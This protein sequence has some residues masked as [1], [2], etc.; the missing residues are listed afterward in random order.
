MRFLWFFPVL[1][2]SLMSSMTLR[3]EIPNAADPSPRVA[4][5]TAPSGMVKTESDQTSVVQE[6]RLQ[7]NV[8]LHT[9]DELR[10]LLEKAE[11]IS[12]GDTEYNTQE[13][14]AVVL[15]GEE[16]RAFVRSNYREH[17]DLV[18]LAARLDAFN[19]VD[20]KV[21]RRWM[22]MNGITESDLPPFV[23]PVPW[24]AAERDRLERSGY[25]YF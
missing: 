6:Q 10:A 15:H 9:T 4:S 20:V 25:A 3:A 23:E 21:C 13:P 5:A 2:L 14:V 11:K 8:E 17:K 16:I 12:N 24:G 18:D 1:G 22:G 7:A 19:V